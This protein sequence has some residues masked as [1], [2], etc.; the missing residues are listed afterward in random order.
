M[1]NL[2][3]ETKLVIRYKGIENVDRVLS[4]FEF[5]NML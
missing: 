1:K 4:V 5:I 3:I 2:K